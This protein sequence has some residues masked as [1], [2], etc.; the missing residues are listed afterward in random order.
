MLRA[1]DARQTDYCGLTG[2]LTS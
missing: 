1:I 2:L